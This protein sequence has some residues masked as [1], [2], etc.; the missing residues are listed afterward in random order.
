MTPAQIAI[1]L[2]LLAAGI[3][4]CGWFAAGPGGLFRG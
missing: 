4:A 1:V 2:A 3:V